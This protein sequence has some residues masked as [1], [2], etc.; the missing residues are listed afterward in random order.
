MSDT[1]KTY[2]DIIMLMLELQKS[3]LQGNRFSYE[4]LENFYKTYFE[5]VGK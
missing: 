3:V 2:K 4:E 5:R 1:N